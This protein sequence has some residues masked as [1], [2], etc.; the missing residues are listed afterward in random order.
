MPHNITSMQREVREHMHTMQFGVRPLT[1]E[2]VREINRSRNRLRDQNI[3]IFFRAFYVALGESSRGVRRNEPEIRE[4]LDAF[5]HYRQPFRPHTDD[6]ALF[7][8]ISFLFN[9][10]GYRAFVTCAYLDPDSGMVHGDLTF[11]RIPFPKAEFSDNQLCAP[12]A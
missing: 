1:L 12:C 6:D 11:H 5:D 7:S 3:G 4:Y 10:R 8:T 2:L 9:H